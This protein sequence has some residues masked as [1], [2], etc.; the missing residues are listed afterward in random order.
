MTPERFQLIQRTL[1][2]RQ[3]DLTV[4]A[5]GIHKT[6]NVAAVVRS[7]DAVGVLD[8]HAVS[9]GGEIP[10]HHATNAGASR[11]TRLH[12]HDSVVSAARAL[13]D[14]GFQILAAHLSDTAVDF[15]DIDYC[16]PTAILLGTELEGVSETAI[17]QADQHIMVPMM[18]MV[19]SLNVSVAAAVILY[20]A[21]RQ[22]MVAKLYDECRIPTDQYEQI[23]FEWTYPGIARRCR[24]LKRPYPALDEEGQ[25]LSNP[26]AN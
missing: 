9:P 13:K 24:E 5:D 1:N 8:V 11:W 4:L 3:P 6:H 16:K 15:R 10:R 21:Q 25:M 19:E 23:L 2:R 7:C 20:E 14:D 22:R 17:E 12:T 26:L 18:G